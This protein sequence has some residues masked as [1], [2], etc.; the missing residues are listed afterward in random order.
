MGV[1][2]VLGGIQRGPVAPGLLVAV[3]D[4]E[5]VQRQLICWSVMVVVMITRRRRER[6][7]S[8]N[9][10]RGAWCSVPKT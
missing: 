5:E 3:V 10:K 6:C 8:G 1:V 2:C 4:L 7:V 9:P